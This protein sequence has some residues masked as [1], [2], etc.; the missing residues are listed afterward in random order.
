MRKIETTGVPNSEDIKQRELINAGSKFRNFIASHVKKF[1][2]FFL[3]QNKVSKAN[4]P[5]GNHLSKSK[6]LSWSEPELGFFHVSNPPDVASAAKDFVQVIKKK[7]GDRA[8]DF[9]KTNDWAH[10]KALKRHMVKATFTMEGLHRMKFVSEDNDAEVEEAMAAKLIVLVDE[11]ATALSTLIDAIIGHMPADA[12]DKYGV[13]HIFDVTLNLTTGCQPHH[14]DTYA[15]D[16][17]GALIF[18]F[19]IPFVPEDVNPKSKAKSALV[20]FGRREE[21]ESEKEV[22][23][24]QNKQ[25]ASLK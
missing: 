4:G 10:D 2:D 6:S 25:P 17:M 3:T 16:G 24:K 11:D 19:Y 9:S 23:K 8:P 15:T 7:L 14:F 5:W 13:D 12:K 20:V 21:G 22:K 18:N 1:G